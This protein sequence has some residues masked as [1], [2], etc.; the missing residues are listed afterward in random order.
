MC[1][2]LEV[3]KSGYYDWLDSRESKRAR[4]HTYLLTRIRQ[5]HIESREIYGTPR[6]H[7]ELVDQGE[8]VGK[9]TVAYLM[10]REQVQSK[11]HKRFVVTTASKHT[12]KPAA[13]VLSGDFRTA[14]ADERWV[15]DVTPAAESHGLWPWMNAPALGRDVAPL[16]RS[17]GATGFARGAP[18]L[19]RPGEDGCIWQ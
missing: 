12:R 7:A 4:R 13:N 10:R 11:V 14:R 6:I 9:N 3:S 1:R 17:L 16:G 8:Q 18:L 5:A 2:V 19:Y 15:S